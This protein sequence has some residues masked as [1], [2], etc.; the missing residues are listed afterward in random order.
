MCAG[1]QW[2]HLPMDGGIYDQN[3]EMLERFY[4]I[5]GQQAKWDKQEADRRDAQKSRGGM[6]PTS[7][8]GG[9]RGR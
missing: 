8:S 1:M 2:N 6:K 3:P 5:M 4:Y 7:R 9:R